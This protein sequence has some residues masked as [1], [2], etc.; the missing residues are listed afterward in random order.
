[1]AC[2]PAPPGEQ[3]GP[4]SLEVGGLEGRGGAGWGQGARFGPRA[5]GVGGEPDLAIKTRSQSSGHPAL[6]LE[7]SKP[8]DISKARHRRDRTERMAV[9]TLG[10]L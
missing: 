2:S 10:K 6:A 9:Q 3:A 8:Q 1:M 5:R 7:D 4:K